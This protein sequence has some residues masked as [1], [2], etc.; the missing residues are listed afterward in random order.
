[1]INKPQ[2][3]DADKII[4]DAYNSYISDN[5]SAIVTSVTN[6]TGLDD[7]KF[8]RAAIQ[9]F[10]GKLPREWA[11]AFAKLQF[12]DKPKQY[13]QA[14]WEQVLNDAG[15]F[16]DKWA[17]Q[18]MALGWSILDVFAVHKSGNLRRLDGDGV[19]LSI[20]GR[21]VVAVTA[22]HIVIE[23]WG[24]TRQRIAKPTADKKSIETMVQ[25]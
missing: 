13:S 16:A 2:P 8:E 23:T 24:G 17:S 19:I 21:R 20:R 1:M 25:I 9:E 14:E 10:D 11:E 4:E 15:L 3:I 12:I 7:D 22:D 5:R 18:A 6:V